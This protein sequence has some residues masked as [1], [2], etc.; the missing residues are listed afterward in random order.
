MLVAEGVREVALHRVQPLEGTQVT[1]QGG[2][3]D[4]ADH[5]AE[6]GRE[7]DHDEREVALARLGEHRRRDPLEHVPDA[8]RDRGGAGAI[9]LG[10]QLALRPGV[11]AQPH[12]GGQHEPVAVE[13]AARMLDL[14]RVRA[15]DRQRARTL[16]TDDQLD[17]Q[18]GLVE[19][20]TERVDR[21]RRRHAAYLPSV[22]GLVNWPNDRDPRWCIHQCPGVPVV[23]ETA[24]AGTRPPPAPPF[25]GSRRK[26][27]AAHPLPIKTLPPVPL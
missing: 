23:V 6:R 9:E 24:L 1:A 21:G 19:Q 3:V 18:V 7:R 16:S 27:A 26:P 2:P 13:P 5:R 14:D 20:I 22:R 15:R 8:E 25:I 4:G 10:D 12:A 17:A 11:A